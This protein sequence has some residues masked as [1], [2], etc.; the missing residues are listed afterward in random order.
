MDGNGEWEDYLDYISR[1]I[2][3]MDDSLLPS[4]PGSFIAKDE[5]M[6]DF[7]IKGISSAHIMELSEHGIP[8]DYIPSGN[9]T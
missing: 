3:I 6:S 5:P 8:I 7:S 9:L 1:D 4:A 2:F